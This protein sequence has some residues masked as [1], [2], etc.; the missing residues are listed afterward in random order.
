MFK[1]LSI[2]AASLALLATTA[3]VMAQTPTAKTPT[4]KVVKQT[5]TKQTTPKKLKLLKRLTPK[6]QRRKKS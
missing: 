4:K 6:R 2:A 5:A 1:K 3:P